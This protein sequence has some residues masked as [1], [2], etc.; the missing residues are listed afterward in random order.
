MTSGC[1]I[2]ILWLYFCYV[3]SQRI[4]LA[5]V[6]LKSVG[7]IL[8]ENFLCSI[9]LDFTRILFR[10]LL[11]DIFN[12]RRRGFSFCWAKINA[13]YKM[14]TARS[15]LCNIYTNVCMQLQGWWCL[16]KLYILSTNLICIGSIHVNCLPHWKEVDRKHCWR[17]RV[18]F[19]TFSLKK[20]IQNSSEINGM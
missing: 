14:A 2:C 9:I 19:L 12:Q 5:S 15:F 1:G 13:C 3:I 20:L 7:C 16:F 6:W 11:M 8:L 4:H 10:T 17:V 18:Q